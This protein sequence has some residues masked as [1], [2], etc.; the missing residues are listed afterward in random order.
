MS[1]QD[2][3]ESLVGLLKQPV[4]SQQERF[5]SQREEELT[6]TS[7]GMGATTDTDDGEH[8]EPI[9]GTVS[10]SPPGA[11]DAPLPT[12]GTDAA[13]GTAAE[14]D[15]EAAAD[16]A[17]DTA[18]KSGT[19]VP[20]AP[21][22]DAD[23]DADAETVTV[24]VAL[25]DIPSQPAPGATAPAPARA[26]R[27]AA[28]T[29]L[30]ETEPAADPVPVP[31]PDSIGAAGSPAVPAGRRGGLVK[32]LA[33]AAVIGIA[34]GAT[35]GYGIQADRDPSPLPPLSQSGLSHPDKP[36]PASQ[37]PAALS[38]AEDSKVKVDGDLR[39]LL[40]PKPAGARVNDQAWWIQDGWTNLENFALDFDQPDYIYESILEADFRRAAAAS[41]YQGDKDIH[42]RLVQFGQTRQAQ[43]F[44][45]EQ[46]AY[47]PWDDEFGAGNDG[48]VIHGSG[49]GRYYVYKPFK[50][51]GYEPLYQARALVQRGSTVADINILDSKPIGKNEIRTLAEQQLERL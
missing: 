21:V 29:V 37:Q 11:P 3:Q 49:N 28:L 33:V 44:A 43:D 14:P 18:A 9:T 13:T 35:V 27:E 38:A 39:R 5:A 51:A 30:P 47:M 48:D 10:T 40:I 7:T 19:P 24:T 22:A 50:E 16:T 31:V 6:E 41:W 8:R 20:E 45:E 36:L 25:L 46:H 42:V 4:T 12:Q 15:E 32:L 1:T 23:A 34:V 26:D 2:S 17:A